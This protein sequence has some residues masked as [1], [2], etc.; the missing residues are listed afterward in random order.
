MDKEKGRRTTEETSNDVSSSIIDVSRSSSNTSVLVGKQIILA[1]QIPK[2]ALG[3]ESVS[4]QLV[5]SSLNQTKKA[6][7]LP[8]L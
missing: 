1:C 6:E 2:E 8:L 7:Q 3:N 5:L 4:T